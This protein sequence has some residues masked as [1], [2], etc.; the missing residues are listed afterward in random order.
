MTV[1]AR[2]DPDAVS[3]EATITHRLTGGDYAD[4]AVAPVAVTVLD[5]ETASTAVALAVEPASVAEDVGTA[6]LDVTVTATL[7]AAP[8]A[9]ATAVTVA[10]QPGTA[11]AADFAAVP[12]LTLAIAAGAVQASA[13][14]TLKPVDDEVDEDDETVTVSGTTTSGL[15]VNPAAGLTLTITDDDARGVTVSA[16]ALAIDEGASGSY[17]VVLTSQPTAD[18]TVAVTVPPYAGLAA[19]P[20]GLTFTA[21]DWDTAQTVTVTADA[22]DDALVP[23]PATLRHAVSGADYG[24]HRVRAADVTVTIVETTVPALAI[25]G[26]RAAESAGEMVFTVTLS[27]ADSQ[28]VLSGYAS[29]DGTATA[30]Q[31]YTAVRGHAH[32]SRHR[33]GAA[34]DRRAAARRRRRRGRG[35]DLHGHAERPGG[36]GPRRCARPSPTPR[37]RRAGPSPTTMTRR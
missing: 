31:D 27:T 37:R 9:E 7:N 25:A 26:G 23:A 10:V 29:A 5:D 33:R 22:D 24:A 1:R 32:L 16:T 18:V 21:D 3:D 11:L 15:A 36:R 14:F 12:E 19:D 34:Q 20:T 30:G 17:T 4:L 8:R 28:A 35:R 13:S 6:G 2:H